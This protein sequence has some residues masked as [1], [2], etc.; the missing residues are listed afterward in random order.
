MKF[1]QMSCIFQINNQVKDDSTPIKSAK[2][3][4]DEVTGDSNNN[5]I[6]GCNDEANESTDHNK[7]LTCGKYLGAY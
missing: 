2:Q 3:K 4:V 7:T 1:K 5:A 6:T